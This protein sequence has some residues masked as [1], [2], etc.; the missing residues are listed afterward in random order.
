[1]TKS[2]LS[3]SAY[4]RRLSKDVQHRVIFHSGAAR[5]KEGSVR[6]IARWCILCSKTE[7]I[8]LTRHS[9]VRKPV[10]KGRKTRYQ[11]AECRV[12]LCKE[13]RGAS[14]RAVAAM[15]CWERWHE[16]EDLP[17]A[18]TKRRLAPQ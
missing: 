11:C 16:V 17:C 3:A 18:Q 2:Q 10:R 14:T 9:G 13:I 15:S 8:S 4:S 12:Y 1:M 5:L 7:N 6:G